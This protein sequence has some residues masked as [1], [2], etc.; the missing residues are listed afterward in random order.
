MLKFLGLTFALFFWKAII[1]QGT[2]TGEPQIASPLRNHNNSNQT[3]NHLEENSG[4][5]DCY[6]FDSEFESVQTQL[7]YFSGKQRV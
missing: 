5:C 3:I 4:V 7:R 6:A 1:V 2:N